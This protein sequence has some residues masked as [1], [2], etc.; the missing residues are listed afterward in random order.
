MPP[1]LHFYR[2][3]GNPF[4]DL[5]MGNGKLFLVGKIRTDTRDTILAVIKNEL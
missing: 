1:S 4:Y 3:R 5:K 2:K